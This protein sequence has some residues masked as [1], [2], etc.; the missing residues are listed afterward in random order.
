[1]VSIR[2]PVQGLLLA[3]LVVVGACGTP[4][5]DARGATRV[6][7]GALD[8][9]GLDARPTGSVERE[10]V[11]LAGK[12][13]LGQPRRGEVWMVEVEVD[14]EPWRVGVDPEAGRVVR[15]FEPAGTELSAAQVEALADHRD[16]PEADDAARRRRVVLVGAG[17]A[18]LLATYLVV[19]RLARRAAAS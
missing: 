14:G 11:D 17:V 1:M 6:A 7:V 19:R 12:D 18:T 4:D 16:H 3:V 13:D 2:R 10:E 9:A 5:L 15:T 8:A